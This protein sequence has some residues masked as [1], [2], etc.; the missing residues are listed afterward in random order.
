MI[1]LVTYRAAFSQPTATPFG[2]KAY[3]LLKMSG[4]PFEID[5][6]DD[7]RKAP[8]GKFPLLVDDSETIPDSSNIRRHLERKYGVDF[9]AGLSAHQ[10]AQSHAF[11]RMAE[12]HLYWAIVWSLW[13]VDENWVGLREAYFANVPAIVRKPIAGMIRKGVLRNARG[14]G[15]GRHLFKDQCARA[16]EDMEAI[17]ETLGEKPF[18]HG[19]T[20]TGAD[21]TLGAFMSG[22]VHNTFPTPLRE[23][24]RADQR[25]LAYG[26]RIKA[27]FYPDQQ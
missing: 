27:R 21:A 24:A 14:H 20:P 13:G 23:A 16:I 26:E 4:Q 1:K 5:Y 19:D 15:L 7:P 9:D 10:K 17:S 6:Q 22:I 3:I 11:Q 18:F 2:V 12:E 25:L 8:M